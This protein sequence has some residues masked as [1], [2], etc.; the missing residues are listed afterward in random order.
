MHEAFVAHV[1]GYRGEKIDASK[2]CTGETWLGLH[3]QPL[4]LVDDL[5]TSDTYL[6]SRQAEADVYL[7]R[8]AAAKPKSPL[9]QLFGRVGETANA[10][11]DGAHALVAA[12]PVVGWSAGPRSL[13]SEHAEA[14]AVAS[15]FLGHTSASERGSNGLLRA[16]DVSALARDASR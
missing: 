4:G 5:S 14:A 16:A 15:A 9:A 3:A 11:A 1:S 12:L 13:A 10:L 7:L 2:V 6:R 8:P